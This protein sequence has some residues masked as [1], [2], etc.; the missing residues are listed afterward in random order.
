MDF[1]GY[2]VT[3][4]GKRCDPFTITD[5]YSRYLIR[6]QIVSRIDLSQVRAICEAAMREPHEPRARERRTVVGPDSSWHSVYF[7]DLEVGELH[8]EELR[9]RAAR[10]VV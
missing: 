5:A 1:K 2:F 7:R 8:A 4:D 10:R 6:C 9:F 3:G